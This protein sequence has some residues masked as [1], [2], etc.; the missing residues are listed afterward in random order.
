M[1]FL[2]YALACVLVLLAV[3]A[4]VRGC[5][6]EIAAGGERAPERTARGSALGV[7]D[8]RRHVR[9][10]L[11]VSQLRS[12]RLLVDSED[13]LLSKCDS[14]RCTRILFF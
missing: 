8:P 5:R 13:F 12:A 11:N 6:N 14:L 4:C 2:W 1:R 10:H 7:F 3:C 9:S